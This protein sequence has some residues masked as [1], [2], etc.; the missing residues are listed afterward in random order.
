MLQDF[1]SCNSQR[2]G[3]LLLTCPDTFLSTQRSSQQHSVEWWDLAGCL[4]RSHQL[5]THFPLALTNQGFQLHTPCWPVPQAHLGCGVFQ[6][7]QMTLPH[8]IDTLLKLQHWSRW[9]A[10]VFQPGARMRS[11]WDS[12]FLDRECHRL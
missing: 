7:L 6:G 10:P 4:R 2:D 12:D 11:T 9:G 3:T 8:L 5:S 1:S